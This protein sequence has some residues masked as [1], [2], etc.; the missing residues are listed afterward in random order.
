MQRQI[1][2]VSL[3]CHYVTNM[4]QNI[5]IAKQLASVI[6]TSESKGAVDALVAL[7]LT[8]GEISQREANRIYKTWF[9]D[10][11]RDR[12]ILP[13]RVGT[14]KAA[15]KWY[16]VAQIL[17]LKRHDEIIAVAQIATL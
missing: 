3:Y 1:L 16:S 13:V 12:R 5:N 2:F 11:V 4:I 7:G 10:A 17:E 14:G 9:R 8:P 15:T 6:A